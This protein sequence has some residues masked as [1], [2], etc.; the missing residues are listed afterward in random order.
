MADSKSF[1]DI[2]LEKLSQNNIQKP[3]DVKFVRVLKNSLNFKRICIEFLY[4]NNS[5]VLI[6]EK[7]SFDDNSCNAFVDNLLND[8]VLKP[9][10]NLFRND[11]YG[12]YNMEVKDSSLIHDWN[13]LFV[14]IVHPARPKDIEKALDMEYFLVHETPELYKNVTKPYIDSQV[15]SG[16][17]LWLY[18]VLEK[19]AEV[20]FWRFVCLFFSH[21]F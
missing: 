6:L 21:K 12:S 4:E 7:S 2:L 14:N 15:A 20:S 17:L 5:G 16:N 8:N 10:V 1:H 3:E 11:S 9:L 13:K 19:K 18:N